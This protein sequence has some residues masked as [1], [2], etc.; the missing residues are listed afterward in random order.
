M[1]SE[2]QGDVIPGCLSV[3]PRRRLICT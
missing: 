2:P 3:V 1:S